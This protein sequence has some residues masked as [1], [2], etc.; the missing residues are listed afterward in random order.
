MNSIVQ[1]KKRFLKK[2]FNLIGKRI[3]IIFI[4]I[5]TFSEIFRI[6]ESLLIQNEYLL[7]LIHLDFQSCINN[8]NLKEFF[9]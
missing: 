7:Q 6:K 4:N 8:I 5:E 9:F 3:K 2:Y 1:L